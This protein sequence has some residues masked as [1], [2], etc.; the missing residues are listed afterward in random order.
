VAPHSLY[1]PISELQQVKLLSQAG[2]HAVALPLTQ[3]LE[4]L[5]RE[6]DSDFP[7]LRDLRT[8]SKK[9]HQGS[10]RSRR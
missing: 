5:W 6:A 2:D 7:P 10:L 9:F 3:E 8:L 4:E 1:I